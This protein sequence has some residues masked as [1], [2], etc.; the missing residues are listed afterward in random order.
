M[1][2]EEIPDTDHELV[3]ERVC[4]ID[5]A[6]ASGKVCTRIPPQT[7][8]GRRV[9]RVWDVP[10][11]AN[12][13]TE[14]AE[15]LIDQGTERVTI[16]AT[17]DYW[18]I[19]FYL[20]E[21]VGLEVQLVN[22]REVK[23]VPGRPKTD[24]LDAVWLAKLTEKGMLRPSFVPPAPSR[25][26]RDYTRLR[27]DLTRERTRHWQR[28]EKLLEDALIKVSSVAS[29]I[30]S[31]SVRDMLEALIGGERDPRRLAELAR[32]RMRT[33]KA[34][35]V[36]ALTGRFDDHHAELARILLDQID[37]LS[38]Q[39]ATLTTRI[40]QLL[41]MIATMV[42]DPNSAKDN[43]VTGPGNAGPPRRIAAGLTAVE[44]LDEIPGVGPLGAQVII[45]EIGLDMTRFP[46]PAHLV[47]WA[48][49]CPRTV[50]SGPKLRSGTPGKGNPYLKGSLGEA[51][52]AAAR[53]D[54]FLGERYR[55]LVKRRGKLKA[56]VAIA[57]SILVTVWHLLADPT[58]R[59]HD[60]GVD[61][62]TSKINTQRRIRDH[63]H[64]LAALGYTVTLEPAA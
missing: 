40:E 51:A 52:A 4:A 57:R 3:V 33:K 24:K 39:I 6:K 19:W 5:V 49:I 48:K 26:L 2:P 17:S 9:S 58:A 7:R 10:A 47:S 32:G 18:R 20:F 38:A 1:K 27:I 59:F 45:A 53:T 16:E 46:T 28:V 12:A 41:A 37:A 34:A 15:H 21:A 63:I 30:D 14:L 8:A 42:P 55:R 54:T 50:Q 35:L 29:S 43:P 44:R 60:L 64:Q 22:A 61:Y 62:Y 56:L 25:N 23:N 36:E 31:R 13:V 11:T